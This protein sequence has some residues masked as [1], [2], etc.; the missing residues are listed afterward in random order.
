MAFTPAARGGVRAV[1]RAGEHEDAELPAVA[2]AEEARP[3]PGAV[4]GQPANDE[5]EQRGGTQRAAGAAR[6][7][8][9]WV[10][11]FNWGGTHPFRSLEGKSLRPE[12]AVVVSRVNAGHVVRR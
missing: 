4:S 12:R 10:P 8:S 2:V 3:Q 1:G 6:Y 11:L 5:P 7:A 9:S